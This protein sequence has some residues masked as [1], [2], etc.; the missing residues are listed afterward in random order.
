M[1][2]AL[3][4]APAIHEYVSLR[5][6]VW[7]DLLAVIIAVAGLL[8]IL[9]NIGVLITSVISHANPSNVGTLAM[10]R[11][12]TILVGVGLLTTFARSNSQ[13]TDSAGRAANTNEPLASRAPGDSNAQLVPPIILLVSCDPMRVDL[14]QPALIDA[15]FAAPVVRDGKQALAQVDRLA[16]KLIII[17]RHLPDTDG[18]VLCQQIHTRLDV[19]VIIIDLSA[20]IDDIVAALD[21]GADDVLAGVSTPPELIARVRAI[22]RRITR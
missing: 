9:P 13:A 11:L 5:K 12:L 1:F 15:G 3:A 21:Y 22:L 4:R 14:L 19:P 20:T 8:S 18:L 6:L 16:P 10:L 17:E 7:I 2:S